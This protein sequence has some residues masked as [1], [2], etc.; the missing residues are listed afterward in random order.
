MN[1]FLT[2]SPKI[3]VK[4]FR[5][6][7]M[8]AKLLLRNILTVFRRITD[9]KLIL[10]VSVSFPFK[11]PSGFRNFFF[12]KIWH[13]DRNLSKISE[14]NSRGNRAEMLRIHYQIFLEYYQKKPLEGFRQWILKKNLI[15]W[16]FDEFLEN[17]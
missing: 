7:E 17:Y 16:I 13:L 5:N 3:C 10:P 15:S 6:S 12:K 14:M 4:K 1:N 2:S 9:Q 11:V 8:I